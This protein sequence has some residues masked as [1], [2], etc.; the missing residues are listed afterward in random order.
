MIAYLDSS[1]LLRK[2]FREPAPLA[3]WSSLEQA[4]ASRLLV[5]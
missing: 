4:Y 1:V 5:V 3:K 2:L